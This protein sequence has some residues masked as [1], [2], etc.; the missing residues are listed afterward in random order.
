MSSD[1]AFKWEKSQQSG[2]F[3]EESCGASNGK[4]STSENAVAKD[5]C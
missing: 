2:I 5:R 1:S 4:I 3:P